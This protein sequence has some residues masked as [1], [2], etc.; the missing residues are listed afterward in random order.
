MSFLF[1]SPP[2]IGQQTLVRNLHFHPCQAV[3]RLHSASP[4]RAEAG[5]AYYSKILSKIHSVVT[6][7][8]ICRFQLEVSYQEPGM[9]LLRLE[10][11]VN[12]HQ[13][14]GNTDVILTDV[15]ISDK[16]FKAAT[17]KIFQHTTINTLVTNEK[18]INSQ[19]L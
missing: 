10:K 4:T 3:K 6:V 16:D 17:E 19:Q 7:P 1:S 12:T 11:R 18:N 15:R 8:Q 2:V 14:R 5:G 13:W 9:C